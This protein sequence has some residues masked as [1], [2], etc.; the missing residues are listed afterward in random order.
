MRKGYAIFFVECKGE[1]GFARPL[2]KAKPV[3]GI[4]LGELPLRTRQ[5]TEK[6]V[7]LGVLAALEARMGFERKG[8]YHRYN[9]REV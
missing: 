6:R 7:A 9:T 4:K 3:V 8:E 5:V 2:A 1:E